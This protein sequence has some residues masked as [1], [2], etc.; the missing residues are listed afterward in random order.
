MKSL[1]FMGMVALGVLVGVLH[2]LTM[3]AAW[4]LIHL[5]HRKCCNNQSIN[6]SVNNDRDG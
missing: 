5:I 2:T 3:H 1:T 4:N 6:Q